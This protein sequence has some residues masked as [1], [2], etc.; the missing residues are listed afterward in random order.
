MSRLRHVFAFVRQSEKAKAETQ[1]EKGR[2][3]TQ[4]QSISVNCDDPAVLGPTVLI[5][6]GSS[7]NVDPKR[8]LSI[9]IFITIHYVDASSCS[10]R[11]SSFVPFQAPRNA[12]AYFRSNVLYNLTINRST[13]CMRYQQHHR[14]E[15]SSTTTQQTPNPL[16][17]LSTTQREHQIVIAAQGQPTH[18]DTATVTDESCSY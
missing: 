2:S 18:H 9:N 11:S 5:G 15:L 4:V 8:F 13:V 3:F 7:A 1:F 14:S 16:T 6:R 10:W 17:I 12:M